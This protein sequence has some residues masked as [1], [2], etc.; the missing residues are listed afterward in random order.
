[1]LLLG[2]AACQEAPLPQRKLQVS[3]CLHRIEID[4]LKEALQ[5]CDR[6][7]QAFPQHPQ[8][9]NERFLVHALMGQDAAACQDIAEAN[10]LARRSPD[11]LDPLLREELTLRL[12][13]CR[14]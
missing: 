1:M 9:R 7:V 10:R 12:A 3:D 6:V 14:D 2:L 8:P 11:R 13:S 4:H 5:R